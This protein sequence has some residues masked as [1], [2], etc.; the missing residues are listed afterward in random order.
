[1]QFLFIVVT[2]T[3]KNFGCALCFKNI[4]TCHAHQKSSLPVSYFIMCVISRQR[5]GLEPSPRKWSHIL[6]LVG[7]VFFTNS[8]R[9]HFSENQGYKLSHDQ[10]SLQICREMTTHISHWQGCKLHV[11]IPPPLGLI[12]HHHHHAN[13]G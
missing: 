13:D 10:V 4:C 3:T 11:H 6:F 7:T 1:M 2:A 8:L 5:K 9:F 12:P